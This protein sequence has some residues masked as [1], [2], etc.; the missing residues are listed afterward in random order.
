[1]SNFFENFF[2]YVRGQKKCLNEPC[3][4]TKYIFYWILLYPENKVTHLLFNINIIVIKRDVY[5][6]ECLNL[7]QDRIIVET[8]KVEFWADSKLYTCIF[9]SLKI[10]ISEHNIRFGGF[11]KKG[12]SYLRRYRLHFYY[13]FTLLNRWENLLR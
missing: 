13:L 8:S 11:K 10:S 2:I 9:L 3:P 12:R 5:Y 7:C 6:M 4:K 1:M